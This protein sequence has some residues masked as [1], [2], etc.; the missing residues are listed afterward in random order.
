MKRTYIISIIAA[1][2]FTSC[3]KWLDVEPSTELDGNALLSNETG[4]ADALAGVYTDMSADAL[5]GKQL[6]WHTLELMGGAADFTY[7]GDN[8]SLANYVFHPK[9]DNYSEAYRSKYIDPIWNNMYNAIANINNILAHIDDSKSTFNANDHEVMKGEALGL[10]AYLH[11]DLARLFGGSLE[12]GMIDSLA[13]PYVT[14]LTSGVY[15]LLSPKQVCE[16]AIKDLTEAVELLKYDPIYLGTTPSVY[17]A[18]AP[19]GNSTNRATYGIEAWHNRRFHFN[20]YAALGTLARIY[21]WMGDKENALKYAQMVI[22]DQAKVF[23][24]VHSELMSNI[25]STS[26]SVVRDRMFCTEQIFALNIQDLEDRM[27]GCFFFNTI[28]M[29]SANSSIHSVR[30]NEIFTS[31]GGSRS[32][33]W[34]FRYLLTEVSYYGYLTMYLTNKFKDDNS[35][36]V[37]PWAEDRMPLMRVSEMYY[38]AAEC[39]P[40]IAESA[41]YI[42]A[43][44]SHRGY[45]SKKLG[46]NTQEKLEQALKEEYGR[47]FVA[48]GQY[49]YYKK[50]LNKAISYSPSQAN[51][52]SVSP[53]EFILP[54][55]LDEDTYGGRVK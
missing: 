3:N 50:R 22:D 51:P 37:S 1:L 19:S 42:E 47:E 5:Y 16:S 41:K 32:S 26:T 48:E 45:E 20:Y 53:E 10:R 30:T 43:V 7:Q 52:V 40:T 23:P 54:R 14:T 55:P 33:D 17:L 9:S 36:T 12:S 13:L 24:W 6:T 44:R 27:D 21:L 8:W 15:P 34:R 18:S 25:E 29:E 46:I 28:G 35:G 49:F 39:A 31:K 2:A 38:I 11:F 4:Y